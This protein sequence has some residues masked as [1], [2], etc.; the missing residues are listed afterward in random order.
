MSKKDD[1][2]T[3]FRSVTPKIRSS[4][5]LKN[6]K[7][8]LGSTD[9]NSMKE[10]SREYDKLLRS[11]TTYVEKTLKF[12]RITK[13]MFFWSSLFILIIS[14][15]CMFICICLAL[16]NIQHENFVYVD[17]IIPCATSFLSFLTVFIIIPKIIAKYLFNSREEAIVK[18]IIASI[19]E[20]DKQIRKNLDK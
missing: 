11:Y 19:Q 1:M 13:N 2:N 16:H 7:A 18:D 5:Q 3:F 9:A 6:D 10:H 20:Y 8:L 14:V 17:Y 15:I 12:K 4:E